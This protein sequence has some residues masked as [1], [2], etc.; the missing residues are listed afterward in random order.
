MDV[1]KPKYDQMIHNQILTMQ[2]SYSHKK[3]ITTS[4]LIPMV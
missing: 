4:L 1:R 3:I 2:L